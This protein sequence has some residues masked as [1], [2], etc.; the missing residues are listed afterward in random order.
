M[1]PGPWGAGPHLAFMPGTVI[2]ISIG[3]VHGPVTHGDDPRPGCSVLI[4]FL[5]RG[6]GSERQGCGE[7][8]GQVPEA[9]A[10]LY[11]GYLEVPFQPVKLSLYH[12]AAIME[13]EIDLGGEGDDV[14]RAQIPAEG[15]KGRS[16]RQGLISHLSGEGGP[17]PWSPRLPV[18]QAF[19][20]P[21]H[22]EAGLVVREVA[23]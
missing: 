2:Q 16:Q 13:E 14:C 8:R 12:V 4:G 5:K 3:T 22:A 9:K 15:S 23:G 6:A 1:A 10:D 21:R 7:G 17:S 18:P 19:V 11:P 20:V